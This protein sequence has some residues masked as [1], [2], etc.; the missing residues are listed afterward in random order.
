[1]V[2]DTSGSAIITLSN[3]GPSGRYVLVQSVSL[4]SFRTV[5]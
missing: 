5:Q 3:I 2:G 1:V 4:C